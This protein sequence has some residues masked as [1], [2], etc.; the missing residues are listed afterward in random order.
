MQQPS[1]FKLSHSSPLDTLVRRTS[2]RRTDGQP[3]ETPQNDTFYQP[4]MP[5]LHGHFA[6]SSTAT[7]STGTW[8]PDN[9]SYV[10]DESVYSEAYTDPAL[11]ESWATG[12]AYD[13]ILDGYTRDSVAVPAVVVSDEPTYIAPRPASGR[14]PSAAPAQTN[15]SRPSRQLTTEMEESKRRVLERNRHSPRHP[16]PLQPGHPSGLYQN[17]RQAPPT[18]TPSTPSPTSSPRHLQPSPSS[19]PRHL[20]PSPTSSRPP[21]SPNDVTLPGK[22]PSLRPS[23]PV[24]L[25]SHYSYYNYDGSTP[26][27]PT[28]PNHIPSPLGSQIHL[29]TPAPTKPAPEELLTLGIAAHEANNLVTSAQ[30]FQQ[31]ATLDGGCGVGMLMWG[32]TLRHGWGVPQDEKAAFKWLR[33]AAEN[34]V[35]DLEGSRKSGGKADESVKS[36]LILAIYEVAQCFF[37]GWGIAKDQKMAVSYYRVAAR[38]GDADA[39][40]DLAFC[41]ANGKGCKKDR[42]EAAKWYRAAV[43]QGASDVGLAWIYKEKFQ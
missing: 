9:Q 30:Y 14:T 32:L 18:P 31:S 21:L 26:S 24:S 34:A 27:T 22:P 17:P 35:E 3:I 39:Q 8:Y 5:I 23:S 29:S 4:T 41:L 13:S 38:L 25:Y 40:N 43:K 6:R 37:H 36:E 15:Y 7:A 16:S 19:S 11:R 10:D 12:T 1:A 2:K 20:Q 42:K 33:R 28:A